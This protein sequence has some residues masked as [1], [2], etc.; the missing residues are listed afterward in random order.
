MVFKGLKFG[1]LLQLAVGPMCLLVF[2]TAASHGVLPGL[3]LVLAIALVDAVYIL[4]AVLGVAVFIDRPGVKTVIRV[5]GCLVLMI[6]GLQTILGAFG[7]SLLPQVSLFSQVSSRGLFLQGLVLTASNPLTILFWSGMFSTRMLEENWSRR[8]LAGFAVGCVLA[9][10]LFLSGVALLG[11][12]IS[13]FLPNVVIQIL[14]VG[15]GLVLIWF[16][17]RMVWGRGEKKSGE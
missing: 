12:L 17:V 2:N 16:G 13:G 3:W 1:M 8:Q 14:N 10:L 11:S 5:G 15:V 9:T 7:L 4:L 6:F